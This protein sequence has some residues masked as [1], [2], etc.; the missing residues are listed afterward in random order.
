MARPLYS[1]QLLALQGLNGTVVYSPPA[2]Y[3]VVIRDLDLYVGASSTPGFFQLIGSSLQV[4]DY[5]QQ[6]DLLAHTHQWRG[7]QC[8]E[9]GQNFRVL[10]SQPMDVTVSGYLLSTP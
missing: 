10:A 1:S 2:G 9:P 5:Y 7:R 8:I 3:V 4:I 6:P